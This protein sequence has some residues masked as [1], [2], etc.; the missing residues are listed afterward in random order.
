M[1]KKVNW[2]WV[3]K[4]SNSQILFVDTDKLDFAHEQKAKTELVNLVL[5]KLSLE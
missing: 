1:M 4:Y 2:E 3:S 5:G